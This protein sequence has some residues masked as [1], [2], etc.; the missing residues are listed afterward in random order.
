MKEGSISVHDIN[1]QK[2]SYAQDIIVHDSNIIGE[3]NKYIIK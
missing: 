3:I 1:D 2:F